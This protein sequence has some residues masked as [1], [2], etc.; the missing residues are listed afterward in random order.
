MTTIIMMIVMAAWNYVLIW[1]W[2]CALLAYFINFITA[3]LSFI[4]TFVNLIITKTTHSTKI[5]EILRNTYKDIINI[6][7][8]LILPLNPIDNLTG[9]KPA[10][11]L[12]D[13]YFAP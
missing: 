9:S 8:I 10:L 4:S 7:P 12:H 5:A 11:V 3:S 13:Q 1:V 2:S 6:K